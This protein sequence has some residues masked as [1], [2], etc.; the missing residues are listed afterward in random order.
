MPCYSVCLDATLTHHF[1]PQGDEQQMRG[2]IAVRYVF[3]RNLEHAFDRAKRL[4]RQSLEREWSAIRE[5]AIAVSFDLE[6]V[7]P[8]PLWRL[9][10]RRYGRAYY[11]AE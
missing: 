6:G 7:E 1:A 10:R 8:A 4:E 3:A 11:E 9:M 5:G 2:Y